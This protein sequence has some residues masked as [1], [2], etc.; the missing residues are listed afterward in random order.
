MHE[1]FLGQDL[2]LLVGASASLNSTQR[3]DP[4]SPDIDAEPTGPVA[5]DADFIYW[6]EDSELHA[7]SR[8]NGQVSILATDVRASDIAV[9]GGG[10]YWSEPENG[11]VMMVS[12]P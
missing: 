12:Q 11:R 5:A 3:I 8:A 10:V 6:F 7:G 2:R 9:C 4:D 1:R